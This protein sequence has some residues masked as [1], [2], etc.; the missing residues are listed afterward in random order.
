MLQECQLKPCDGNG[1]SKL[2][3]GVFV[4][5]LEMWQIRGCTRRRL[6]EGLPGLAAA[7]NAADSEIHV[8]HSNRYS[9]HLCLHPAKQT[10]VHFTGDKLS[11]AITQNH[12]PP[13]CFVT[14]Q[15]LK[16]MKRG[17][18][19]ERYE[20]GKARELGVFI[21]FWDRVNMYICLFFLAL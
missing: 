20:F 11:D 4:A 18:R 7:F 15:H 1:T 13:V 9:S 10:V 14:T 16:H 2:N 17:G 3:I 5:C 8:H 21:V 6:C 19:D 12:L